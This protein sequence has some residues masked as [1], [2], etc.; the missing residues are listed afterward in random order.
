MVL[1]AV[2]FGLLVG[3]QPP[4]SATGSENV[5]NSAGYS[6]HPALAIAPDGQRVIAWEEDGAQIYVATAGEAGWQAAPLV[7]GN[8]PTLA[9]GADG[10]VHL[11]YMADGGTGNLEIYHS[12]RIHDTWSPPANISLTSGASLT[13]DVTAAADGTPHFVWSDRTSGEPTVYYGTPNGAGP[14]FNARGTAPAIVVSNAGQVH[15]VWQ[16]SDEDTGLGEIYHIFRDTDAGQSWSFA[17]NLSDSPDVDSHTPDL[18]AEPDGTLHIAW[19]EGGSIRA[20]AG[21]AWNFAPAIALSSVATD[22]ANPRLAYA[23]GGGVI[24]SWMEAGG[25]IRA[26]MRRAG[27]TSWDAPQT[28][29]NGLVELENIA[30]AA[31]PDGEFYLAWSAHSSDNAA[32]DIFVAPATL[33]TAPAQQ[34][35]YLSFIVRK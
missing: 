32:G 18:I 30:L 11:V 4:A 20:R 28:V 3:A 5:S 14:L 7:D 25:Q 26:A 34:K 12:Q 8:V 24:A 35:V 23:P 13:P 29:V 21:R 31:G 19:V 22:T 15:I 27:S 17:E 1:M 33:M 6:R 16:E 10:R 2:G 9:T